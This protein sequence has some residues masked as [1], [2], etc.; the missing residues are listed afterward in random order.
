MNM[1]MNMNE[2]ETRFIG[3]VVYVCGLSWQVRR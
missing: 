3:V 1:N 2:A